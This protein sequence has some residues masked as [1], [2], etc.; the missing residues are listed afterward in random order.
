MELIFDFIAFGKLKG[1]RTDVLNCQAITYISLIPSPFLG[2]GKTVNFESRKYPSP[3]ALRFTFAT[4]FHYVVVGIP[5]DAFLSCCSFHRLLQL[6]FL[7]SPIYL[8]QVL[9][10]TISQFVTGRTKQCV[11]VELIF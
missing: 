5:N 4:R 9:L 3:I 8:H 10:C 1:K 2:E 7:L 6:Q 11:R